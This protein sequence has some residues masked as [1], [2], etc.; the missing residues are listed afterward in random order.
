VRSSWCEIRSRIR[1][2]DLAK[3]Y[4]DCILTLEEKPGGSISNNI[5]YLALSR[6]D[7]QIAEQFLRF[8]FEEDRE[9]GRMLAAYNLGV[10]FL[11]QNRYSDALEYFRKAENEPLD[12]GASCIFTIDAANTGD[13]CTKEV[14]EVED[15]RPHV[16]SAIEFCQRRI[17]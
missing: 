15:L 13:P 16:K 11:V 10:C 2:I 14:F 4:V 12:D 9:N 8:S 5:G 17:N 1:D 3:K 7:Y 6:K